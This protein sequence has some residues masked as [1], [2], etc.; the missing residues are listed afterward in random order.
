MSVSLALQVFGHKTCIGQMEMTCV[1][2]LFLPGTTSQHTTYRISS[3]APQPA[4]KAEAAAANFHELY[5]RLQA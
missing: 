2:S 4:G 5:R 3:K 1:C